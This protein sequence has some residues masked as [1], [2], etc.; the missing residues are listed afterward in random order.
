MDIGIYAKQLA[1]FQLTLEICCHKVNQM[2]RLLDPK[3]YFPLSL[4]LLL[5]SA[6]RSAI[7]QI[8]SNAC[9]EEFILEPLTVEQL[10]F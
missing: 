5:K 3:V 7:L 1:G 2:I 4:L 6:H 8:S 9:P 10:S